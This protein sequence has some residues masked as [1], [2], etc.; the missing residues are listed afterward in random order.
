MNT[1]AGMLV[2]ASTAANGEK[3]IKIGLII[4]II[5]LAL[6]LVTSVNF[7][8][9]LSRNGPAYAAQVPWKKHQI[10]LYITSALV[11]V[12]SIF[13][14]I[15]YDL[16]SSGPLLQHEYWSYIF[17]ACLMIIVMFVFNVVY[18]G[19]IGK[20]LQDRKKGDDRMELLDEGYVHYP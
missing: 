13:R 1:G 16:G 11:F 14:F 10:A 7:H 9:R 12:R 3:I 20:L 2:Q 8:I 15:E 17:D 4:Q 6:F 5:F 19:E 18:P